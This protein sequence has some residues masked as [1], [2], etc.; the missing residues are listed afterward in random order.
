MSK[1]STLLLSALLFSSASVFAFSTADKAVSNAKKKTADFVHVVQL[2]ANE[3]AQ[4]YKVLL[5]KEKNA[6]A[7]KEEHKGDKKA[8]KAATKPLN[9]K[10]N[11]QIKDII[12]K[13]RM[14]EMNEYNKEKR[15]A[16][17]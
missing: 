7:A 15:A 16:A 4:V 10:Y 5:A 3:E 2:N 9:K 13:D 11:R 8:F 6:L 17:K 1:I 14:K 12:G